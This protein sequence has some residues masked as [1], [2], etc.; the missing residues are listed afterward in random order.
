MRTGPSVSLTMLFT[1]GTT[2]G[3]LSEMVIKSKTSL[4]GREIHS[5]IS[6]PAISFSFSKFSLFNLFVFFNWLNRQV[7][8]RKMDADV[9]VTLHQGIAIHFKRC[10][11]KQ[12]KPACCDERVVNVHVGI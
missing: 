8:I 9:T 5:L 11:R 3:A 10:L 6:N 2:L 12:S 7:N 4:G 1:D